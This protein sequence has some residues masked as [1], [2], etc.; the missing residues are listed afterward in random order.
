MCNTCGLAV[1]SVWKLRGIQQY[2]PQASL[3]RFT[4]FM[5]NPIIFPRLHNFYTQVFTLQN[6]IFISVKLSLYTVFT[7]LIITKTI[8]KN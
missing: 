7:S 1:I 3:T 5:E 4:S 2:F 6:R 8:Y